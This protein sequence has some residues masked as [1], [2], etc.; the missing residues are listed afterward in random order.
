MN[1]F[2][3]DL[4]ELTPQEVN[5]AQALADAATIGILQERAV[6]HGVQL[7]DQLQGALNSRIVIEQAKG[8]VAERLKVGMD[9]A[10]TLIRGYARSGRRRLNEVAGALIAGVLTAADLLSA[11]NERSYSTGNA[12]PDK[13]PD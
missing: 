7:A 3:V 6:T 10:F 11:Q 4:R 8:I 13:R 1:I 5:L 12:R 2:N 9:E